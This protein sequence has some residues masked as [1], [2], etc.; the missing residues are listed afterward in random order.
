[1]V[2]LIGP[3]AS[4]DELH[5]NRDIAVVV[6]EFIIDGWGPSCMGTCLLECDVAWFAPLAVELLEK[7]PVANVMPCAMVAL[8]DL[9]LAHERNAF[10]AEVVVEAQP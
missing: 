4:L 1:M 6:H 9:F 7:K 5:H 2:E 3:S 10:L 8:D